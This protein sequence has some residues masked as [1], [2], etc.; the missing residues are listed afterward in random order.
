MSPFR[1]LLI[2]FVAVLAFTVNSGRTDEPKQDR[3]PAKLPTEAEVMAAKL[4]HAQALIDAITHEDFKK[5]EASATALERISTGAEFF[6]ARKTDE[7]VFQARAFR[8][9]VAR[10]AEKARDKNADGVLLAYQEMSA[11]CVRC[12][13]HTRAKKRD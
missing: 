5:V 7:Y 9:S 12:H 1:P 3:P 6:N 2:A 13:Q 11:N 10:M 4:K 8:Q